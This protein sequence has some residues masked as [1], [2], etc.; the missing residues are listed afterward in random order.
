MHN[1]ATDQEARTLARAARALIDEYG[2]DVP[3]WLRPAVNRLA[4]ALDPFE[5]EPSDQPLEVDLPV[6]S[7]IDRAELDKRA[8]VDVCVLVV[9][10][11]PLLE[12]A[13]LGDDD[14][15]EHG[16][17]F[18]DL[19]AVAVK[20][21]DGEFVEVWVTDDHPHRETSEFVRVL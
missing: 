7:R 18:D 9:A 5:R 4:L 16:M 19:G 2:G 20:E 17:T 15:I 14:L 6:G 12:R 21:V 1:I 8:G 3:D 10:F 11:D 13:E